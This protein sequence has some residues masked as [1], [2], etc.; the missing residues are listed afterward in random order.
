MLSKLFIVQPSKET[1]KEQQ[2]LRTITGLIT[3][4]SDLRKNLHNKGTNAEEPVCQLCHLTEENA[5]HIIFDCENP[6]SK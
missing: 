5:M 4:H 6:E 3:G 2:G 1:G